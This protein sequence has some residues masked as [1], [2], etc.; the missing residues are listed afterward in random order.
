[1]TAGTLTTRSASMTRREP[2]TSKSPV[3]GL[4]RTLLVGTLFVVWIGLSALLLFGRPDLEGFLQMTF[5]HVSRPDAFEQI[6]GVALQLWVVHSSLVLI[7]LAAAW[8]R[9]PDVIVVFEV[10]LVL[11]LVFALISQEWKDPNWFE[12]VAVTTIC[13]LVSAI[14]AVVCWHVV[15]VGNPRCCCCGSPDSPLECHPPISSDR[16]SEVHL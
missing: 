5:R 15:R 6:N 10:G 13:E 14:V 2:A 12:I 4:F 8:F 16:P 7:A 3:G 1:M 11:A 9:R